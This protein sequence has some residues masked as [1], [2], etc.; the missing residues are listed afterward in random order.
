MKLR[1][2][3]AAACAS[4]SLVHAGLSGLWHFPN[5]TV[6]LDAREPDELYDVGIARRTE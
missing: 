2:V 1:S 4:A 5:D 6:H 3:V